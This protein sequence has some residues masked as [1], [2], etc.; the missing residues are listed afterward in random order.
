MKLP[1]GP[2]RVLQTNWFDWRRP[3]RRDAVVLL[4]IAALSYV[5]A[6]DYD[7]APKLFQLG[8]DYADWE[9]DDII[10]VA[11][12]MSIAM[13]IYAFRRIETFLKK[14]NRASAQKPRH[15]ILPA[16]IP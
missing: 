1:P 4:G 16:M 9:L 15:A 2:S 8:I 10:F 14:S 3:D 7:L 5:G 13:M 12:V 6:H 11:F